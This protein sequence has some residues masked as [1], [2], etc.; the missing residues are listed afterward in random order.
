MCCCQSFKE[1]KKECVEFIQE[2]GVEKVSLEEMIDNLAPRGRASLPEKL[3]VEVF[4][5]LRTEGKTTPLPPALSSVPR[6]PLW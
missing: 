1:L 4:N 6:T 5:R 3:K 2:K